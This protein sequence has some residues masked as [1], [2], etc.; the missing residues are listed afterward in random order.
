MLQVCSDG[1]GSEPESVLCYRCVLTVK[2]MSV[3]LFYVYRCVLKMK[4]MSVHLFCVTG[5]F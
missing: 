3:H 5:V 1:E 4:A 2:A